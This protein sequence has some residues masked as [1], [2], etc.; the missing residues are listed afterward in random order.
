MS[1]IVLFQGLFHLAGSELG[2]LVGFVSVQTLVVGKESGLQVWRLGPVFRD[3]VQC[4]ANKSLKDIQLL[5][6]GK[7]TLIL[8]EKSS[9]FDLN[10]KDLGNPM[11]SIQYLVGL[12]GD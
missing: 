2:K 5:I 4:D 6:L 8:C 7:Q 9:K 11:V 10:D 12:I 1:S 3:Q